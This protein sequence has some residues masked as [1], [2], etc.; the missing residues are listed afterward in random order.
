MDVS[1]PRN[2]IFMRIFRDL[3]YVES[4]GSG[5]ARILNAYGRDIYDIHDHYIRITIPYATELEF[6]ADATN[7]GS[8]Q[9]SDIMNGEINQSDGEINQSDGEINRNN[10]EIN[11]NN[12]EINQNN[13]EIDQ[14]NG[15]INRNDGETSKLIQQIIMNPGIKRARLQQ[16]LGVSMRKLDRLLNTLSKCK[17]PRIHYRGSKKTGGWY[18]QEP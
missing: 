7:A 15:E 6:D 17:E 18:V 10:G 5:M 16:I 8:L 4:I 2:R 13:G 3:D 11:R 9:D 12:G 1:M 14:N